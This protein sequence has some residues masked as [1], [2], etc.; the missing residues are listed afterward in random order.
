MIWRA[1]SA[2]GS[3]DAIGLLLMLRFTG[4]KAIMADCMMKNRD[5]ILGFILLYL[6]GSDGF[7]GFWVMAARSVH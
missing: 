1:V 3:G 5:G 4:R 2:L 7:H 6:E